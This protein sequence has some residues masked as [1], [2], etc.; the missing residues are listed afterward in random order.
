MYMMMK[1]AWTWPIKMQRRT[2][3]LADNNKWLCHR[4]SASIRRWMI[5]RWLSTLCLHMLSTCIPW[6][7]PQTH[8]TSALGIISTRL[9][10]N[11]RLPRLGDPASLCRTSALSN[12][13]L[14]LHSRYN[15]N[16]H[17]WN[18][19]SKE[20]EIIPKDHVLEAKSHLKVALGS[21]KKQMLHQRTT[22]DQTW[23]SNNR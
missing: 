18:Q 12:S 13:S 16:L 10:R 14:H 6:Q 17:S 2:K 4:I 23:P 22:C 5:R 11:L 3:L 7:L 8:L 15:S 9:M 21:H 1:S 19:F 20:G